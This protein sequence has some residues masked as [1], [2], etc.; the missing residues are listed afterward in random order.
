MLPRLFKNDLPPSSIGS[1][2]DP[3][4]HLDKIGKK[5]DRSRY[6]HKFK[7]SKS[8]QKEIRRKKKEMKIFIG[9]LDEKGKNHHKGDIFYKS[10]NK[11]V[12]TFDSFEVFIEY[13]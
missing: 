8:E 10:L 4:S 6:P 2:I 9:L 13:C 3:L 11:M 5:M 7:E 1:A 12:C